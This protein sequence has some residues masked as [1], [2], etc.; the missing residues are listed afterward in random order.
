MIRP[1]TDADLPAME[2]I[3]NEAAEA[4]RQAIPPDCWHEPYMPTHE[5]KAEIAAGVRFWGWADS[6]ALIG[7]M[8]IQKVDDATLIRHAY[9]RP[10]NQSR[11]IGGALLSALIGQSNG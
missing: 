11:G 2:A 3:V 6:G 7:V 9:V 10:G 4:Y 1:C 5:L 8:G